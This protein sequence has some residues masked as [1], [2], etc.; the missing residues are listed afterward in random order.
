MSVRLLL[1]ARSFVGFASR[2]ED[3]RCINKHQELF[4]NVRCGSTN[5]NL[6]Q[7]PELKD[8]ISNSNS[9]SGVIVHDN[10]DCDTIPY[11][12]SQTI[13]GNGRQSEWYYIKCYNYNGCNTSQ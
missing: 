8:F 6:P 13:H 11:I 4:I 7:G 5:V 1:Q 3:Y 2:F 9:T 12:N 10:T